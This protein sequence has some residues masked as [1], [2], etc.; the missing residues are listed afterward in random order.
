MIAARMRGWTDLEKDTGHLLL[1]CELLVISS[2]QMDLDKQARAPVQ[3][4]RDQ[5]AAASRPTKILQTFQSNMTIR[6][7]NVLKCSDGRGERPISH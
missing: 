7:K 2:A 6:L 5:A 1:R 3:L 4:S